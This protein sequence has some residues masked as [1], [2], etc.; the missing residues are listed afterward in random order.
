VNDRHIEEVVKGILIRDLQLDPALISEMDAETPLL[1]RGVGLDSIEALR[2]C[3]GLER[4][5]DIQI[6]D[7]DLTVD[8]FATL[9][10]LNAYL[11]RRLAAPGKPA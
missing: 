2:L 11:S 3:L 10:A 5:F 7:G 9:G 1:G 6:P 8:L 4:A